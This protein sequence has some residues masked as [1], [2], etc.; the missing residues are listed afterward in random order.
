MIPNMIYLENIHLKLL[1]EIFL[2][3]RQIVC[4]LAE[5]FRQIACYLAELFRQIASSFI[6]K[7]NQY[8]QVLAPFFWIVGDLFKK[9]PEVIWPDLKVQVNLFMTSLQRK[10]RSHKS[11]NNW[12]GL[13]VKSVTSWVCKLKAR[14]YKS[15]KNWPD[16]KVKSV[17]SWVWKFKVRSHK[18]LKNWPDLKVKSVT[19][20]VCKLKVR[21]H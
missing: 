4:Y 21:S 5:L 20:W 14:N 3:F 18:S 10:V 19:S 8:E 12:P 6:K 1:M 17:T 9:T 15:I 16:L 13:K 2:G 7:K 11:L